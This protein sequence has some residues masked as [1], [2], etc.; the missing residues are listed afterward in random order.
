MKMIGKKNYCVSDSE[1]NE[2]SKDE[3][4][5]KEEDVFFFAYLEGV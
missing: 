4:K 1:M 3:R 2:I 5:E